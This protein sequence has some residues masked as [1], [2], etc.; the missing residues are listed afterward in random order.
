MQSELSLPS[1][2]A[3]DHHHRDQHCSSSS[4]NYSFSD[5]HHRRESQQHYDDNNTFAIA[6]DYDPST[7]SPHLPAAAPPA[8]TSTIRRKGLPPSAALGQSQP[9][10]FSAFRSHL[11]TATKSSSLAPG[12]SR[13]LARASFSSLAS[14]RL[15]D[16]AA[17]PVSIGSPQL[18]QDHQFETPKGGKDSWIV[19][20]NITAE[21]R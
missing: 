3:D 8:S 15:V 6:H 9:P 4:S 10:S 11:P 16:P 17:R 13:P 1:V 2:L 5:C 20:E 14:P 21:A 19:A 18:R 12:D 7:T